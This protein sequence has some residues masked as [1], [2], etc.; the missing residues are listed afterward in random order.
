[1]TVPLTRRR[2]R[3][4]LRPGH[5]YGYLTLN[6][7]DRTVI[8]FGYA[9]QSCQRRGARDAQH[10]D[11]QPWED[12]IVGSPQVIADGWWTADELDRIELAVI[13]GDWSRVR[14]LAE[15]EAARRGVAPG[16]AGLRACAS[17][18]QRPRYNVLGN[19]DNPGRIV[20]WVARRQRWERDAA[21]GRLRWVPP[22][23]RAPEDRLWVPARRRSW[24]VRWTGWHAV[25][26]SW[27]L[28]S[29]LVWAV[30]GGMWDA[31]AAAVPEARPAVGWS[32]VPAVLAAGL[33]VR[34]AW[35]R[36]ARWGR[37]RRR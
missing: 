14:R 17:A 34:W 8:E 6:H 23:E 4:E 28:L 37:R 29:V 2:S 20:P 9:G 36:G 30:A 31:V 15:V 33:L 27:A 21:L 13:A 18:G 7:S 24:R 16:L 5:V 12:L 19:E 25:V 22:E 1:M 32:P 11:G 35:R 10:R 26:P 3:D